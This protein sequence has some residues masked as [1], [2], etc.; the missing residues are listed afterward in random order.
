MNKYCVVFDLDDTLYKEID[1]LKSGY[2]YI[3][4]KTAIT[5]KQVIYNEMLSKYHNGENAFE[6]I[7]SLY[8]NYSIEQLLKW[9]RNHIPDISISASTLE[10][11]DYLKKAGVI[12]G[13]I[14]DG[15]SITQRNKIK[16]LGLYQYVNDK[17]IVISGEFGTPKPTEA[18]YSYFIKLHPDYNFIYVGDNP[19]KDFITPNTLGWLTVGL[20]NNGHN[21]HKQ[22][23]IAP[24]YEPK[25]W[26]DNLSEIKELIDLT[27]G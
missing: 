19:Q 2:R 24:E 15:R 25:I 17:Y 18:N 16:A 21:I 23:Y 12:L 4:T 6:Y 22:S 3:L 8:P 5:D 11:L 26:I 13:L 1:F 27:I 7:Q 20:R 10:C 14:T 9:Y